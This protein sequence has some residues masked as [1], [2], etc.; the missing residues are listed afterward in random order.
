MR[1]TMAVAFRVGV[2]ST[3]A[4]SSLALG[5]SDASLVRTIAKHVEMQAFESNT[6]TY[7]CSA[8]SIPIFYSFVTRTP[9]TDSYSETDRS[10]IGA[11]GAK[12]D[13]NSLSSLDQL[14]GGGLS[15]S[16][17]NV[18]CHAQQYEAF[19][20]CLSS[21]ASTDNRLTMAKASVSTPKNSVGDAT[22]FCPADS[23]VALGGFS[24]ADG[25][26]LRDTASA[27]AWGGSGSPILLADVAD[28]P[29]GPPT[30]WQVKVSNT[31]NTTRSV[32]SIAICGKAPS[33]QAFVY[34]VSSPQVAFGIKP[35]SIFSPVP[36]GWMAVG[37]GFDGG[38]YG[39]YTA[40]D[41]WTGDGA[42]VG[43]LTWF[44]ALG[45]YDSGKSD[46]KAFNVTAYGNAPV[47]V[48]SRS[49]AAVLAVPKDSP[50]TTTATI[51]E[52]YNSS[53][54]HYFITGIPQ[55]ISDLDNG[56]HKGWTRT[57]QSFQGYG[58]GSAGRTGRRPV[59][60][61]YGLP[62]AGI[63]SHFYSASL[64]ECSQTMVNFGDAW[65]RPGTWTFEASEV[66]QM[67]LPDPV[68]GAC[69][70]NRVPIYRVFNQRKDANHRYTTSTAIR[71][72]MVAKGGVAEG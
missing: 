45:G 12:I 46:V 4:F 64:D 69:S 24:S 37:S 41:L 5:Q 16:L 8:G 58:I 53:L 50:P 13:R 14:D 47:G 38:Q 33:L 57:D 20:G 49:V 22:A 34:S 35:F 28:G 40:T 36:D 68:T 63:D 17:N 15:V 56:V 70:A 44:A 1:F 32:D 66:F 39:H 21:A 27:P 52:F 6:Y 71:D 62:S 67:E 7:Q 25:A 60:R 10:M 61:I 29:T 59:C 55:E 3:V 65:L 9:Q 23:P 26:I 54:D 30:G 51:V 2:A 72:R 19:I 11:N 42:V 31:S 18:N 48:T 43:M